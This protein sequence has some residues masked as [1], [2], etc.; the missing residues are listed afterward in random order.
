MN[1]ETN[2]S[3]KFDKF[4][5]LDRKVE[6]TIQEVE[7]MTNRQRLHKLTHNSFAVAALWS[8]ILNLISTGSHSDLY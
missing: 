1:K 6:Q 5:K 8:L 4:E 2:E 7:T 3:R